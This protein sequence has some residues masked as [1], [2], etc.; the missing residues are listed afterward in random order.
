MALIKKDET[1]TETVAATEAAP[2]PAPKAKE[3]KAADVAPSPAK[4]GLVKYLSARYKVSNNPTERANIK[5]WLNFLS[6]H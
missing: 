2:V 6:K 3:A 1:K 4:E 5:E